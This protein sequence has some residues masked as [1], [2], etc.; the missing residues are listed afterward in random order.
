MTFGSIKLASF[1]IFGDILLCVLMCVS[2][3]VLLSVYRVYIVGN[4]LY[5]LFE[6]LKKSGILFMMYIKVWFDM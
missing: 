1:N 4:I 5:C 3:C 6:G 2:V